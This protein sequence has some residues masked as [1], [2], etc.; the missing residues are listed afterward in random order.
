MSRRSSR[1]APAP[2]T[3]AAAATEVEQSKPADTTV[4]A[5]T[6]SEKPADTAPQEETTPKETASPAP[7]PAASAAAKATEAAPDTAEKSELI[8]ALDSYVESMDPAKPQTPQSGVRHQKRL[9]SIIVNAI[10]LPESEAEAKKN[11]VAIMDYIKDDQSGVFSDYHVF[12][13]FDSAEWKVPR[14]RK[15]AETLL[16]I[17]KS[18]AVEKK[19][20]EQARLFDWGAVAKTID[21]V[22]SEI[23]SARLRATFGIE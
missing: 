5:D 12:R 7:K 17:L 1:S 10:A 13:F 2:K 23:V 21:P 8:K 9:H 20:A 11:I 6:A 4:N 14:I 3:D 18:C 16:T 19:R 15:E 22:R